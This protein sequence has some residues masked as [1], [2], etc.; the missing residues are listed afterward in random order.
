MSHDL[1]RREFL[2]QSVR[3]ET[4]GKAAGALTSV[5]KDVKSALGGDTRDVERAG[6]A[7][8]LYRR[9]PD[10]TTTPAPVA[11][12]TPVAAAPE[13]VSADERV[14]RILRARRQCNGPNA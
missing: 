10:A 4:V 3:V 5:W 13:P 12:N 1:T 2:V 11:D 8:R 14:Q 7:M 6:Q 9:E